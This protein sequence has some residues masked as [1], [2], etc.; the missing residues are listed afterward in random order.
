MAK[1]RSVVVEGDREH[2][3]KRVQVLFGVNYFLEITEE[4]D[5]VSFLLGTH[6]EAFK[7]NAS[8]AKGELEQ[9]IKEIMDHHPESVFKED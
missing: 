7:A 1:I 6:H 8:E 9:F 5:R 2:G 3:Y 4:G